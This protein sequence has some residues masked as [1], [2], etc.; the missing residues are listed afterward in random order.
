MS[1]LFTCTYYIDIRA[2][3]IFG[4]LNIGHNGPAV[5]WGVPKNHSERCPQSIHDVRD[6]NIQGISSEDPKS[7][8]IV[9]TLV[10]R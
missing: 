8:L 5:V 7:I 6:E 2:W 1:F 3:E 9:G 10:L 4:Y